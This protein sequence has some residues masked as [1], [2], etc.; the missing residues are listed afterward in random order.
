MPMVTVADGSR[1]G[2]GNQ[3]LTGPELVP[4]C[5]GIPK[6]KE[7]QPKIIVIWCGFA[8]HPQGP[9]STHWRGD[10]LSSWHPFLIA[11]RFAIPM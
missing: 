11:S 6:G 2:A 8:A 9:C 7:K 3:F 10:G 1:G 5:L 4:S